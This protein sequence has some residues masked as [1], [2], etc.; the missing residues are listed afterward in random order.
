LREDA[1]PA[2]CTTFLVCTLVRQ[3]RQSRRSQEASR[4]TRIRSERRGPC[5]QESA[6]SKRGPPI[7]VIVSHDPNRIRGHAARP[8]NGTPQ[9]KAQ[10]TVLCL[11]TRP[12]ADLRFMSCPSD[13]RPEP[14]HTLSG[15][16]SRPEPLPYAPSSPRQL[17]LHRPSPA[18]ARMIRPH[19]TAVGQRR[20]HHLSWPQPD[21]GG[22][23]LHGGRC[24]RWSRD[25][26]TPTRLKSVVGIIRAGGETVVAPQLVSAL[27][28]RCLRV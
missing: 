18:D 27:N 19:D 25:G 23:R 26:A 1:H 5:H 8:G 10:S 7:I 15:E 20:P 21:R 16:D 14:R 6:L 28:R 11:V 9:M 24:S 2:P 13:H 12:P 17:P 4:G 3:R 22:S